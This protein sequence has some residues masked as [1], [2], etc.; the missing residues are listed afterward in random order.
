MTG[1]WTWWH[2]GSSRTCDCLV[3]SHQPWWGQTEG[4]RTGCTW[5]HGHV[6][7]PHRITFIMGVQSIKE[8]SI[9]WV[10]K[11][12]CVYSY[13]SILGKEHMAFW[14]VVSATTMDTSG[15]NPVEFLGLPHYSCS[16][17]AVLTSEL[18]SNHR[19]RLPITETVKAK[20]MLLIQIHKELE[21]KYHF[22][23]E[24]FA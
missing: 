13:H 6:L 12:C 22:D 2:K 7:I 8:L 19:W 24:T 14:L 1:Q 23:G 21:E 16:P 11:G 10:L 5:S 4:W 20:Y 17:I 3:H 9:L 18:S 15:S